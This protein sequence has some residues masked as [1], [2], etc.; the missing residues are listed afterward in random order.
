MSIRIASVPFVSQENT[1]YD[2]VPLLYYDQ[3]RFYVHGLDTGFIFFDKHQWR[4]SALGRYR[5]FNVPE[6]YEENAHGST[7]DMG[8]QLRY[9]LSDYLH[10]DVEL[11]SED[12]GAWHANFTGR[13]AF[14]SESS[15]LYPFITLRYKS[16][17][18]NNTYY[19]LSIR[20]PGAALDY[21]AGIEARYHLISNLY[22]VDSAP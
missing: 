14:S 9:Q 22:L 10:G 8:G 20:E 2:I 11:L 12:Y 19:G 7:F 15:E 5:F 1:N 3:G 4:V 13:F 16:D 17:A 6:E 21:S 18:F